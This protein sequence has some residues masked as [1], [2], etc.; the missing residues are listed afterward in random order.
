[1]NNPPENHEK[2]LAEV[3][4]ERQTALGATDRAICEEYGWLQQTYHTW[5]KGSSPRAPM[6][7]SIALFT[8]L[9]VEE[10]SRLADEARRA[11]HRAGAPKLLIYNGSREHGEVSDAST[12]QLYFNDF[13]VGR[14]RIP[15]GRY[16]IRMDTAVMEPAIRSG[17]YCWVD[18]SIWVAAG[19]EAIV[20]EDDGIAWVGQVVA[21]DGGGIELKQYNPS[22][23]FRIERPKAV[24]AIALS[25][26]IPG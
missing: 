11:D 7:E 17:T 14:R 22:R 25:S 16:A 8:G 3:L 15:E 6:H 1:M 5:K 24:H 20:H 2:S 12:G 19:L 13:N 21:I 23:N 26:R 4:I 18:Q 9:P 10:I